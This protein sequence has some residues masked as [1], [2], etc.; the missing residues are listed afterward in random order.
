MDLLSLKRRAQG[1]MLREGGNTSGNA[2]VNTTSPTLP[3]RNGDPVPNPNYIDPM[4][5][6][7]AQTAANKA[8]GPAPGQVWVNQINP[9]SGRAADGQ[10]VG[11]NN[12]GAG[13]AGAYVDPSA[14][15]T[16]GLFSQ[17]MMGIANAM[18]TFVPL[19][20][21]AVTGGAA[22][23][24]LGDTAA[25]GGAAADAGATTLADLTPAQ[26][27]SAVGSAGYGSS[28][29]A[30]GALG[31][32]ATG[33]GAS[34]EST[35][36]NALDAAP[37]APATNSVLADSAMSTP[38]YGVSSAGGGLASGG[39]INTAPS[40]TNSV[41]A[42]ALSNSPGYGASAAGG[43]EAS[44]LP[45]G[46]VP[47]ITN[48]VLAD[49]AANSPGYGASSVGAG[50][51]SGSALPLDLG[52]LYNNLKLANSLAKLASGS[53]GSSGSASGQMPTQSLPSFSSK[54]PTPT[55][56]SNPMLNPMGYAASLLGG[57]SLSRFG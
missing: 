25:L 19:A 48:S 10:A 20:I 6:L 57:T 50:L 56:Y 54:V 4:I 14:F 35:L 9:T 44:M 51:N 15:Q 47:G 55:N 28:A 5:A 42:D 12:N 8:A 21:A 26:I 43:G 40:V 24:L 16:N 2:P 13:T 7:Q 49:S 23:G 31:G 37:A 1:F 11:Y 36:A 53:G 41:L 18:P 45:V 39:V 22:S 30:S 33:A 29:A 52:N 46:S 32:A 38:G 27:E 3:N 34:L 17:A